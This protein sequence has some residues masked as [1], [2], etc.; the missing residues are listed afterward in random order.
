MFGQFV[1]PGDQDFAK[2]PYAR[3]YPQIDVPVPFADLPPTP[4]GP[5]DGVSET[6]HRA[7]AVLVAELNTILVPIIERLA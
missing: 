4:K 2:A 7:V 6:A 5:D 3:A 1:E